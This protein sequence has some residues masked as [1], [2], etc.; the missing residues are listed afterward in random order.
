LGDCLKR[1]YWDILDIK[2]GS[3]GSVN[4]N[5]NRVM[6]SGVVMMRREVIMI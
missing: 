2:I 6:E 1:S 3:S 5:D 4:N